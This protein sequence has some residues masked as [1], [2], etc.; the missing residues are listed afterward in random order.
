MS[1]L[2]RA[3]D[4]LVVPYLYISSKIIIIYHE[5]LIDLFLEIISMNTQIFG[6]KLWEGNR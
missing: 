2:M 6:I 1:N 5:G 4:I 3:T